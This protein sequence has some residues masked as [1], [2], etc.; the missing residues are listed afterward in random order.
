MWFVLWH[1]CIDAMPGLQDLLKKHNARALE[2]RAFTKQPSTDDRTSAGDVMMLNPVHQMTQSK[3]AH[4]W[5]LQRK[6]RKDKF[7]PT[8]LVKSGVQSLKQVC[9]RLL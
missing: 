8:A 6:K 1:G 2:L 3:Q 9:F 7:T 5:L 4:K